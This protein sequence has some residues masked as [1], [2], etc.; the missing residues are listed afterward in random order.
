MV[1]TWGNWQNRIF[2]YLFSSCIACNSKEKETTKNITNFFYIHSFCNFLQFI[3]FHR[4]SINTTHDLGF[5]GGIFESLRIVSVFTDECVSFFNSFIK[6]VQQVLFCFNIYFFPVLILNKRSLFKFS[7]NGF[8]VSVIAS[9]RFDKTLS[10]LFL[11][12]LGYF[13]ALIRILT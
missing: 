1:K 7:S 8:M 2:K 3:L 9:L 12:I 6:F 13:Y 11:K 5:G 4:I 10:S